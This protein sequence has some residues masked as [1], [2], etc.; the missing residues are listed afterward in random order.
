MESNSHPTKAAS[1]ELTWVEK[2]LSVAAQSSSYDFQY[3]VGKGKALLAAPLA[4]WIFVAGMAFPILLFGPNAFA[5]A[6]IWTVQF[7]RG[8]ETEYL[9]PSIL[10]DSG[11]LGTVSTIIF[12][13]AVVV[14]L[15]TAYFIVEWFTKAD[16]QIPK[17]EVSLGWKIFCNTVLFLLLLGGSMG[18]LQAA[19]VIREHAPRPKPFER[20]PAESAITF[21]GEKLQL[22]RTGAAVFHD[23]SIAEERIRRAGRYLENVG[24][25]REGRIRKIRISAEL[26]PTEAD[27]IFQIEVPIAGRWRDNKGLSQATRMLAMDLS[28]FVDGYADDRSIQLILVSRSESGHL[29]RDTSAV[30]RAD[31]SDVRGYTYAYYRCCM[32]RMSKE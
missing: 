26:M 24:L 10:L 15:L 9:F 6:L 1:S 8:Q 20:L 30:V 19:S 17:I 11:G 13:A 21:S 5:K 31:T 18:A 27:T 32:Y 12:I 14:A 2:L 23:G 22:E 4:V 28:N 7:Y 25:L 3:A 16:D 29:H